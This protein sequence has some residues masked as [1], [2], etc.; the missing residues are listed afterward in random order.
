M[1]AK[2]RGIRKKGGIRKAKSRAIV[3]AAFHEIKHN[4]PAIL[5]KTREQFGEE[6]ARRQAIAIGLSKARKAGAKLKPWPRKKA[7]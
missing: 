5:A 7:A 6:R 3:K 1:I 2:R 4:P